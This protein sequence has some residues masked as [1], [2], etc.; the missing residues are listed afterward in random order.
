MNNTSTF[1]KFTSLLLRSSLLVIF[2][3]HVIQVERRTNFVFQ[4]LFFLFSLSN[5]AFL[6]LFYFFIHEFCVCT[7]PTR[8]VLV[9]RWVGCFLCENSTKPEGT[10]EYKLQK[11]PKCLSLLGLDRVLWYCFKAI[12]IGIGKNL[13]NFI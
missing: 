1:N 8:K 7:M 10:I 2:Y 13:M 3:S 12:E 11:P 4:L 5:S 6:F 9:C